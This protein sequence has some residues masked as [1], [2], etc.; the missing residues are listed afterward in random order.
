MCYILAKGSEQMAGEG[1][2][3]HAHWARALGMRTGHWGAFRNPQAQLPYSCL[4]FHKVT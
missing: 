1:L 2:P 4:G 3:R